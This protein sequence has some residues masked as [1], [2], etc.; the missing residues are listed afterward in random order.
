[1][2]TQFPLS[3]CSL[4][5][6]LCEIRTDGSASL[7]GKFFFFLLLK[8]SPSLNNILLSINVS[9]AS[10]NYSGPDSF[11][12]TSLIK[13]QIDDIVLEGEWKYNDNINH[14]DREML[15]TKIF[16]SQTKGQL[17]RWSQGQ[18]SK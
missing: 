16:M 7:V 12:H 15:E 11:G 17:K 5:T 1:M 8:C 2:L 13:T 14:F 3:C 18:V 10:F 9:F 4:S 6:D